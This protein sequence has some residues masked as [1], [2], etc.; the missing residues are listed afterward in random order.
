MTHN[1]QDLKS[2]ISLKKTTEKIKN[3]NS[4][5]GEEKSFYTNVKTVEN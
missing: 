4:L 3:K 2:Q 5:Q 1:E